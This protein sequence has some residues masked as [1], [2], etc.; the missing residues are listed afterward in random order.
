MNKILYALISLVA[1]ASCAQSYN[2]QGTSNISSLDG[3]KLYLKKV[4]DGSLQSLDSCDVVHGQ[5]AFQGTFDS[6]QVVSVYIGDMNFFP[7]V[8]EEGDIVMRL[9]N[10]QRE[11]GGTPLNDKLNQFWTKFVQLSNRYMEI[12]HQGNAALLDGKD[13]YSVN[14]EAMMKAM[15]VYHSGDTLFTNFVVNNFDNVLSSWGFSTRV[16]YD[17]DPGAFPIWLNQY[18]YMN[19]SS[20]LPSWIEYIMTKAPDNFKN[21]PQ[22]KFIYNS[23]QEYRNGTAGLPD[24][25]TMPVPDAAGTTPDAVPAPPTPAEM[26][27]DTVKSKQ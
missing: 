10:G 8:M 21:D 1:L 3:R 19:A 26:A 12:E 22:V 5:F 15:Q 7:V 24:Q 9:D 6:V 20:Q 23:L 13:E 17:S 2:I 4:N 11:V 25:R 14:R 16:A 18:L 27:G